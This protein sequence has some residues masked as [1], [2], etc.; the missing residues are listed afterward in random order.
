LG[1]DTSL[2]GASLG[3]TDLA[4]KGGDALF[5]SFI[6]STETSICEKHADML[7]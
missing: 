5:D 2:T 3:A 7:M 6:S 1:A 4:L